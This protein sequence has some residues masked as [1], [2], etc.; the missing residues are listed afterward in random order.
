[1]SDAR[2]IVYADGSCLGNPGPGGWGCIIIGSDGS[3]RELSGGSAHTTNN[4]ME[5]TAAIEA[6]RALPAGTSV[7]VHTD[8]QYLVNT[9]TKGWRRK[10]NIDLWRELDAEVAKRRVE[11]EWVRGHAGDPL[12][13]R[14][15]RLARDAASG[16]PAG[17]RNV[18]RNLNRNL[19]PASDPPPRQ[20]V[21]KATILQREGAEAEESLRL[22]PL[23]REDEQI[24][25]CESCG[26]DFVANMHGSEHPRG[27]VYCPRVACQLVARS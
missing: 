17:A 11:W 19:V 9:M 10:E 7:V 6:L 26:S 3:E 21:S 13:E 2:T 20:I 14:A 16:K 1:M 25:R 4:R 15:D 18:D 8:S 24:V 5:I 12:N 23:L 22:R 27:H